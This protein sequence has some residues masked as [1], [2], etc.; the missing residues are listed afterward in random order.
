VT[1]LRWGLGILVVG[2]A[3]LILGG[4]RLG[5]CGPGSP[6][7]LVALVVGLVGVPLGGLISLVAGIVALTK[8]RRSNSVES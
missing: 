7:E 1:S 5:P 3:S 2:A 6:A 4:F 8:R